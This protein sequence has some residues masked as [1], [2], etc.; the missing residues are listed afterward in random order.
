MFLVRAPTQVPSP[1]QHQQLQ[2]LFRHPGYND[3]SNVL[4]RLQATDRENDG[5]PGLFAQLALDACTIV[6]GDRGRQGWLSLSRDGKVPIEPSS[7]LRTRNYYF[8]LATADDEPYPIVPNFGQWVYPHDCLPTHWQQLA[9]NVNAAPPTVAL[10]PSNLTTA[11]LMRDG[12]CRL[13]GCCEQQQVAHVVP[14]S[15]LSWWRANG[16]SRY[17][18]G[19]TAGLDD[20]ANALLL[21][22][23]LHIAFDTPRL[24]FVPKPATDGSMRLVAHVLGSSPELELLYH[25]RELHPTA[26]SVDM[27]YARF[28]WSIFPLLCAFLE[29]DTDRRLTLRASDAPLAD[30]WGFVAAADCERFSIVANARRSQSPKKR[31]P[32]CDA[33]PEAGDTA[34]LRPGTSRSR[35]CTTEA[36]NILSDVSSAKRPCQDPPLS[37]PPSEHTSPSLASLLTPISPS[38]D[39]SLLP[40]GPQAM[41]T[42]PCPQLA[43]AWL[44]VERQRSDADGKW[45]KEQ[46]WLRHVWA[47]QTMRADEVKRWFEGIGYE[48]R[49]V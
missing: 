3:S 22:A 4:F 35:G 12:S 42:P 23:D 26:V 33:T 2:I 46:D 37:A 18:T 28:A 39:T 6:A 38:I 25:N 15:E 14:Q 21:R 45:N 17:N 36:D 5:Q 11:L 49:E 9:P 1:A 34:E 27:L 31:K 32:N 44:E 43:Q 24:A 19:L 8:H 16:M 30:A 13:S 29:S 20:M 48:V 7:T 40:Q 10:A 47:G 41:P